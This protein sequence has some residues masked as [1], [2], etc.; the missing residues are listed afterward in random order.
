MTDGRHAGAAPP[1][2]FEHTV[3]SRP[4]RASRPSTPSMGYQPALDGL[5]ALSV[6]AVI[7]YHAGFGWMHGGFFGVEV[8]FVV[9][10]FLITSLLI[11]ERER[12]GRIELA[13]VLDA[14]GAPAAAGARSSCSSTVSTWTAVF[15]SDEQR[16]ADAARPAVVDLLRRQLGPDPRRRAVLRTRRSA[17]AP[18]PVEPRRRGAVVPDLAVRVRA[19]DPQAAHTDAMCRLA[20]RRRGRRSW[21]SRSGSTAVDRRCSAARSACSTGSDRTN[22]MYLSTF[23]RSTGL[24]LGAA[25]AFVWR[26]WRTPVAAQHVPGRQT[27]R[28]RAAWRSAML[29][30]IFGVAVDHRGL[31]VP[32]AAA[33]RVDVVVGGGADGGAP[34]GAR[35]PRRVLDAAARRD[36]SPELRPVPLALADLRVRRR[37]ARLGRPVRRSRWLSL[38]SRPSSATSSSRRRS[39]R[40]PSAFGGHAGN[41]AGGRALALGGRARA[42]ACWRSTRTSSRSTRPPVATTPSSC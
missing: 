6:I 17:A 41:R 28:R 10:G 33:A 19:A 39:A 20:G 14:A 22:F 13:S 18:A 12:S 32:V 2:P 36:R 3:R 9:S 23:T 16:V 29:V 31:R 8:F 21:C 7:F 26:P 11:E 37:D 34:G 40:A 27:R 24:L 4:R 35:R 5:R 42:S 30:C 15:G 38:R 25:A 1:R